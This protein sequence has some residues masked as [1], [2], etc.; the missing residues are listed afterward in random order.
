MNKRRRLVVQRKED[1]EIRMDNELLVKE[2]NANKRREAQI[3]RERLNTKRRLAEQ[4]EE[5]R[6]AARRLREELQEEAKLNELQSKYN[7]ESIKRID[8]SKRRD[9]ERQ[10]L[11]RRR[12]E[13][14]GRCGRQRFWPTNRVKEQPAPNTS[15]R[16]SRRRRRG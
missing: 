11:R 8:F 4:R 14:K 5:A 16:A 15:Y 6:I 9:F 1:T 7:E 3:E 12:L 10:G 2:W 13:R